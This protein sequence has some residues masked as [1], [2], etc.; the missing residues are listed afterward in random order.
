[1]ISLHKL[2]DMFYSFNLRKFFN[3]EQYQYPLLMKTETYP[4][5]ANLTTGQILRQAREKHELSQQ[6]VAD[7]LCLK[8]STVRDI[9]EDNIPSNI[10]PTFIRG[11]IRA[12]AKLVQVP[13]SEILST[14]DKQIPSKA[15]KTAPMQSFSAGK[16]RKKRDGWLMKITWV[17]IV[18]LLGMTFLWWWQNYKV[19]QTELSSMATQSNVQNNQVTSSE[20]DR[21][22]ASAG[23]NNVASLKENQSEATAQSGV[24]PEKTLSAEAKG[25][26]GN[27]K[28]PVSSGAPVS[29]ATNQPAANATPENTTAVANAEV[30]SAVVSP[31]S[32]DVNSISTANNDELVIDFSGECWLA[33]KDAKGKMLFSGIKKKG[34][35]LKLSGDLPYSVNIGAPAKVKVQFRGKPVDLSSFVKKGVTAKLTL[36]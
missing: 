17:V 9:E 20:N 1:M 11:Y 5:E 22:A 10:S 16:K 4:E 35:S 12:Y 29:T 36:K 32:T 26:E 28:A 13:E 7:R 34:D 14:L 24:S 8:L 27:S 21:Q 3:P 30:N 25:T 23:E 33:V 31:S 19:Q 18:L 6:T 2:S 15:I